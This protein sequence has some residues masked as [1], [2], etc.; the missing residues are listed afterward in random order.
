MPPKAVVF[1]AIFGMIKTDGT[2]R[3]LHTISDLNL[4]GS[5]VNGKTVALTG[6]ATV[7]MKEGPVKNVPINIRI[8]NQDALSIWINPAKVN[9]HFGNTP[10]YGT[11]SSVGAFVT[12][13]LSG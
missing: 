1:N 5:A 7:A 8:M 9:N 11:V 6:F 10:I 3:H 4:T 2:A 12:F 13:P